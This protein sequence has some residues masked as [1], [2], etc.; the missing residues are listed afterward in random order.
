MVGS[1]NLYAPT[2]CFSEV[3]LETSVVESERTQVQQL[4]FGGLGGKPLFCRYGI[5]DI[6]LHCDGTQE[7]TPFV[8]C[9]SEVDHWDLIA[10]R[11]SIGS[12]GLMPP[13][14]EWHF[15]GRLYAVLEYDVNG[16]KHYLTLDRGYGYCGD[17]DE[18]AF[19]W[20]F[21]NCTIENAEENYVGGQ[22]PAYHP[23]PKG[24][25]ADRAIWFG[26]VKNQDKHASLKVTV[27]RVDITRRKIRRKD[28]LAAD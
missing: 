25:P 16:R 24:R 26:A 1:E 2:S 14:P 27:P 19:T 18:K 12:N 7:G 8:P 15:P 5:K 11:V 20:L 6:R 10:N 13:D 3:M 4:L 23:I 22:F 28:S 9:N 21:E 17:V